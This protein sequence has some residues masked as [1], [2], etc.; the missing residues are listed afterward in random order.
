MAFADGSSYIGYSAFTV[1]DPVSGRTAH[2]PDNV[3]RTHEQIARFS[4]RD[5]DAYLKLFEQYEK[6]WKKAFHKQRFVEPTP[7]GTPDP[8]EALLTSPTAASSRCTSS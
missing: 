3:K 4:R 5:A 7:W 1:V 2:S 8:L 6:Y